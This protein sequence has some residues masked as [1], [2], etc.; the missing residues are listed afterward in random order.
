[1]NYNFMMVVE[2]KECT[3]RYPLPLPKKEWSEPTKNPHFVSKFT[4]KPHIS[5]SANQ[6]FVKD[7]YCHG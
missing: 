7:H 5:K 6:Q 4:F 3:P 2:S 1:L